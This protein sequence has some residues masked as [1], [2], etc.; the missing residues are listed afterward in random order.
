MAQNVHA[1]EHGSTGYRHW[2]SLSDGFLLGLVIVGPTFLAEELWRGRPLIDQAGAWWLLPACIM[3]I[4]FFSGGR[5]AGRKRRARKGAFTQGL[6]TSGLTLVLIFVADVIRRMV[7]S[8]GLPRSV[9]L[10]WLEWALAALL[11]GGLGG[12]SG[13][14]GTLK[15]RTRHQMGRFH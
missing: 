13:R 6:M 14:R 1:K 9:L 10:V 4:G 2:Q 5:V 7:L 8:D 3:A 11:A 12:L 15:A